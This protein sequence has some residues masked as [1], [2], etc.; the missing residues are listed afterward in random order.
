ME[1]TAVL[2]VCPVKR[3]RALLRSN[4]SRDSRTGNDGKSASN[5]GGVKPPLLEPHMPEFLPCLLKPRGL[6]QSPRFKLTAS[7][8]NS[9]YRR[10]N[11]LSSGIQ[12]Q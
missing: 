5:G 8:Q 7:N 2:S 10:T 1:V 9:D 12:R 6:G 4:P 3:R 11:T